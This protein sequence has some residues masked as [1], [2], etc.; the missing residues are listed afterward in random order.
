MGEACLRPAPNG[1]GQARII[2]VE[3]NSTPTR[4]HHAVL[5]VGLPPKGG[6]EILSI[7]L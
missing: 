3:I 7:S 1:A 6:T 5:R 2:R 4:T